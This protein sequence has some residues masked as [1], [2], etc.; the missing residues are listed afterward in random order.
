MADAILPSTIQWNHRLEQYLAETGERAHCYAW[1][2]KQAEAF[3]SRLTVFIDLPVIILGTINGSI[4][5]GSQALF[6]DSKTAPVAIGAVV[7]LTAILTTIGSYFTWSRRAEAHKISSL[8]Y[9]K[10]YRF[11]SVEM[12][13]PR[14]ER[15]TPA[16]LLKYVKTEYDRLSE[17]SP[18]IPKR[19]IED[20]KIRFAKIQDI[21][22]P[23]ET[24]GLHAISIY[25]D[26]ATTPESSPVR[27]TLDLPPPVEPLERQTATGADA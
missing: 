19:I 6:G 9:A 22:K 13:L 8:S 21:T 18:L 20:F 1:L 23:E 26:P 5:V 10:L 16:D 3:Y 7:L 2:H 12:N 25:K 17:I 27:P 14:I 15:M 4:S 24:N 11:L